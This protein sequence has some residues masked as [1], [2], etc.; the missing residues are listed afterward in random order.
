MPLVLPSISAHNSL[1][2]L[3]VKLSL[4]GP[5][6]LN[7]GWKFNEHF[8]I[9]TLSDRG[10]LKE[11]DAIVS[12]ANELKIEVIL[13]DHQKFSKVINLLDNP[14]LSMLDGKSWDA[15][16]AAPVDLN[17]KVLTVA[18]ANPLDH[19]SMRSL[20]F[21]T[22]LSIK[23]AIASEEH[24]R[25]CLARKLP[26]IESEFRSLLNSQEQSELEWSP[27]PNQM[28]SNL[29]SADGSEAPVIRLVNRILGEGVQAGASDIHLSPEREQLEVR[30]RVDGLLRPLLAIPTKLQAAVSSRI[31]LLAGMDIS[32]KRKPQDGRLRIKTPI[33]TRDLRLST[34]P[35][36]NGEN[37]VIRILSSD[38]AQISFDSLG[39]KAP[40]QRQLKRCLT[41]S[42]KVVLVTGPT[43]SGK[44]ST[45]YACLLSLKDAETNIITIE[46]PIEYR[47]AGLNQTQVNNKIGV[48]FA[49]GLRAVLRQDPDIVMVGEIRDQ[50]T[51]QI[52]F[53]AAQTGH[54][55]LSTLH[56]N[57]ASATIL[58][59]RDIG[60]PSYIIAS[61]LGA[62]IAQ[63]LVRKLCTSCSVIDEDPRLESLKSLRL[64]TGSV[65]KAVGC[66]HC[67]NSGYKGR[68]AIHS[69]LEVNDAVRE[70]IREEKSESQIEL[71]AKDFKTLLESGV[72]ALNS[73]TTSIEELERALG[74][75]ELYQR[76][77]ASTPQIPQVSEEVTP[78]NQG[79][80]KVLLVEDDENIRMVLSLLLQNEAYEVDE[81]KDGNEA[82][83]MI[84]ES[85][86]DIVICDL[87]MPKLDGY[88]VVRQLRSDQQFKKLPILILTAAQT[89]DNEIK[90][91]DI[92]ADDFVGK[93]SDPKILLSRVSRLL[94]R[95]N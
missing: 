2:K 23:N 35:T 25:C 36:A 63:R 16:K 61:C 85:R 13:I 32:E 43:G 29:T 38:L 7:K 87:M 42:S 47:I 90:L 89:E 74:S 4:I 20:E 8:P 51:A 68:T 34:I 39:L 56:T 1:L 33:G 70:A 72:D 62:I 58:R 57:S 73:G 84:Y 64:L 81:A 10:L 19:E 30:I 82:I 9:A 46:D 78:R 94:N 12:I 71:A 17:N 54:L 41:G 83:K 76:D 15:I 65:K 52:S 93:T 45:L 37:I 91:L 31:K 14:A 53:Q 55:V 44:T 6:Y 77:K 27:R 11:S 86:P 60:I 66:E 21:E 67:K 49:Q 95:S 3:M 75:L 48:T 26:N 79:L 28:E 24:I 22:G 92:G 69:F 59:L 80:K 40:E 5:E 50:E 88:G 18:F